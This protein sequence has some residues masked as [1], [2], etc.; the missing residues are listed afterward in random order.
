MNSGK[1]SYY[2]TLKF[3]K[4]MNN[5]LNIGIGIKYHSKMYNYYP[6]EINEFSCRFTIYNRNDLIEMFRV[7]Y[8][9]SRGVI[10]YNIIH[11]PDF[12]TVTVSSID[13]VI[14]YILKN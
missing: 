13:E 2:D 12:F 14:K 11:M 10:K 5:A 1:L 3:Y 6:D 4:S 9:N 7:V 8:M